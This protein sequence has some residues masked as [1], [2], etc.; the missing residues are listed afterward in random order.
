MRTND[1]ADAVAGNLDFL[2]GFA[3]GAHDSRRTTYGNEAT[4]LQPT[5]ISR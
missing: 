2:R 3:V 5:R 1:K 4:R